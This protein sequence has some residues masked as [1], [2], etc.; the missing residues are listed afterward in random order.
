M[1]VELIKTF[2]FEAAH[3]RGGVLHGHSYVVEIKCAGTCDA[4]FG[5]L[6]DYGDITEAFDPIY[7]KLDH[8]RLEEVE[9]LADTSIAGVEAWL[10]ARLT[11]VLPKYHSVRV[12]IG[13]D[14]AFTARHIVERDVFGEPA[15]VRFGFESAHFLP[16]VPAEHKCR[17]MHG[18]SFQV[19]V[20]AGD[21]PA[22]EPS[23]RSVYDALDRKCLNEI[24]G[25]ENATS[26]QVAR[27]IWD[28]L[29]LDVHDLHSVTVAET[30]TA[31]CVYRGA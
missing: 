29:R 5:W 31:R 16:N 3:S 8:W 23:L 7:R 1:H 30:C 27:W 6:V 26:E 21:L 24:A 19:E 15:R 11:E 25:L 18:H 20:A 12:H 22:L 17:R 9:G 13:G 10:H 4:R 2:Q 14:C 28:R